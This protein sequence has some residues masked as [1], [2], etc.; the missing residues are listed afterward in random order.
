MTSTANDSVI[1]DTRDVINGIR[2]MIKRNKN[3]PIHDTSESTSIQP[4]PIYRRLDAILEMTMK[5]KGTRL[6]VTPQ[7]ND[8]QSY[9]TLIRAIGTHFG[10]TLTNI[11]LM[12]KETRDVGISMWLIGANTLI[13]QLQSDTDRN[14]T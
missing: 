5:F 11:L 1:T 6:P 2:N 13:N 12:S 8:G 14:K 10:D 4:T 9:N 3:T 7:D